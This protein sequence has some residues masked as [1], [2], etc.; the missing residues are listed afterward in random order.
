MKT[1]QVTIQTDEKTIDY[2][3][4]LDSRHFESGVTTGDSDTKTRLVMQE[5]QI[6]TT[7][8]EAQDLAL[9]LYHI[10]LASI[11]STKNGAS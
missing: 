8:S 6:G 7:D 9:R 3:I 2:S 4:N 5:G 10:I 1:L 11:R